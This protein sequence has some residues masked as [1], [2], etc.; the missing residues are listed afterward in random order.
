MLGDAEAV[1]DRAIAAGGVE[2]RRA[3]QIAR[4]ARR[5]WLRSPRATV[6]RL[7]DERRPSPAN[8]SQ[9]QRSRTNASSTRPSVTMTCAMRGQHRDIGAGLQRQVIARPRHAACAPGR[10]G[11]DRSTISL[12]PW[13]SRFFMREA[14]T[15]CASVGLAPI[16]MITSACFDANRNP[17]CRPRCR[18]WSSGRSRSA[19]GRRARRYRHCCCRSRRGP[20]SAPG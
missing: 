15:G 17:G 7:G 12:A 5:S 18:R 1:I 4:P 8:S 3:A 19:S 16:T 6:A 9:S 10:C 13:R 11:A 2:P 14:K 20:A